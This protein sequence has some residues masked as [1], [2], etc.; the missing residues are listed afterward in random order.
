MW[1]ALLQPHLVILALTTTEE[2]AGE[3]TE[4]GREQEVEPT[5]AVTGDLFLV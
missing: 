5:S 4:I 2:G 3:V 1:T